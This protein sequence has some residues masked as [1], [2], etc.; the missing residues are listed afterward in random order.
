MKRVLMLS[1]ILMVV[2]I[3][4]ATLLAWWGSR[5]S[6]NSDSTGTELSTKA[7][8]TTA[9]ATRPVWDGTGE[10]A[11]GATFFVG[12]QQ[13]LVERA[14]FADLDTPEARIGVKVR[15]TPVGR[16]GWIKR[17]FGLASTTGKTWPA[18]QSIAADGRDFLV[19]ARFATIPTTELEGNIALTIAYP[20]G[21]LSLGLF[22]P[23]LPPGARL[24]VP[25]GTP[26]SEGTATAPGGAG[27]TTAPDATGTS[28][29]PSG[30]GTPTTPG[31]AGTTAPGGTG[32]T[33]APPVGG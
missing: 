22:A 28:T 7:P 26:V 15:I 25:D 13:I 10:R 4:G 33:T 24:G 12:N 11:I 20:G 6:G 1:G 30:T 27:T 32:T 16:P 29:A 19:T 3:G 17:A 21:S 9:P 5:D 18:K 23:E 31:G 8:T 14:L 2:L